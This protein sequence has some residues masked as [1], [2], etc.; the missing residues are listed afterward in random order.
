MKL[1]SK[2]T[3]MRIAVCGVFLVTSFTAHANK[4]FVQTRGYC[5]RNAIENTF[6]LHLNKFLVSQ[7][8]MNATHGQYLFHSS[9]KNCYL[10]PALMCCDLGITMVNKNGFTFILQYR[11]L[12]DVAL[13]DSA[14]PLFTDNLFC[15]LGAG[16]THR[17][18]TYSLCMENVLNFSA[19]A[20]SEDE[21]YYRAE[22]SSPRDINYSPDTPFYCKVAVTAQF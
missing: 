1:F 7:I 21:Y 15:N 3:L 13:N 22:A 17:N 8:T 20:F 18:I 4:S 5:N 14:E 6:G 9:G 16:Y 2:G 12:D 10:L 19:N 11:M